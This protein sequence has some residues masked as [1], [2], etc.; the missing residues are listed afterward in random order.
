MTIGTLL[1]KGLLGIEFGVI[2]DW[3]NSTN[4]NTTVSTTRFF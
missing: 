3:A 1:L 2:P 4:F